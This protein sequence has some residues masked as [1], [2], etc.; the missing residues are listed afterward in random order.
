MISYTNASVLQS[1][2]EPDH[3]YNKSIEILTFQGFNVV[4]LKP[5]QK[6]YDVYVC[7]YINGFA[8][9][10]VSFI[11]PYIK[12]FIVVFISLCLSFTYHFLYQHI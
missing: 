8:K 4:P 5:S 2:T 1:H 11:Y 10:Y 7:L 6:F 3:N 9:F 12:P